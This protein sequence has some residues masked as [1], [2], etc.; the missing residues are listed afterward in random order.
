MAFQNSS[1]NQDVKEL[2][3]VAEPFKGGEFPIRIKGGYEWKNK[4]FLWHMAQI[5]RADKWCPDAGIVAHADPDIIFTKPT[6]PQTFSHEGKPLLRYE[7]FETL[8]KRHPG[9]W[10][11]KIACDNA[12]PFS[13]ANEFMRGHLHCHYLKVYP[14]V[15][16]LVEQKTKLPFDEY[17]KSCKNSYPQ[18]FAEHPTIGAV[19]YE[20]F[21]EDYSL[22][23]LSK[24]ANPDRS[25]YPVIQFWSHRPPDQ[26]QEIVIDGIKRNIIPIKIIEEILK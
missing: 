17:V 14:K 8:C 2:R 3:E 18:T 1:D 24:D 16:E 7:P 12:L 25:P 26:E 19:A 15:R 20:C 10:N 5:C 22:V 21:K 9:V 4:G 6:T 11:W 13:V 23:D